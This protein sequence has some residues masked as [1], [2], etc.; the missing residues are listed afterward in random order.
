[1]QCSLKLNF[2]GYAGWPAMHAVGQADAVPSPCLQTFMSYSM[3]TG[4]ASHWLLT[5]QFRTQPGCAECNMCQSCQA[6][7]RLQMTVS[8]PLLIHNCS[9]VCCAISIALCQAIYCCPG[10][11]EAKPVEPMDLDCLTSVLSDD[12]VATNCQGWWR[13]APGRLSCKMAGVQGSLIKAV[14]LSP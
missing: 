8:A 2:K 4:C 9:E 11:I 5:W 3:R 10:Y 6:A 13:P 7:C 12:A 14:R 1:M